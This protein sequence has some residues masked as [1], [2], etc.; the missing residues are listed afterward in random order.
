MNQK[1][2]TEWFSQQNIQEV[3]VIVPDIAGVA[4]GKLV[5]SLIHI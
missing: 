2:L 3:E 4:R 1:E 5:L